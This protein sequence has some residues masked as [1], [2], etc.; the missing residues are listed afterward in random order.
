MILGLPWFVTTDD[1][2]AAAERRQLQMEAHRDR[3][4]DLIVTHFARRPRALPPLTRAC[5]LFDDLGA[6]S[7][8]VVEIMMEI[9]EAFD[10]DLGDEDFDRLVTIGDILG[11]VLPKVMPA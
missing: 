4:F 10:I 3:V 5:R 8:D 6:D 11:R 7:L 2:K 9:E 1:V